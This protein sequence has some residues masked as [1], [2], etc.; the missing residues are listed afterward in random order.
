MLN[1]VAN[2]EP[3]SS[4]SLFDKRQWDRCLLQDIIFSAAVVMPSIKVL[5]SQDI[6]QDTDTLSV[7]FDAIAYLILLEGK[8]KGFQTTTKIHILSLKCFFNNCL[9]L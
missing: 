4:G 6:F 8:I 1:T 2:S 9:H 3:D 7:Y 5:F